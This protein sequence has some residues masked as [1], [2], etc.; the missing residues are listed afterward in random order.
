MCLKKMPGGFLKKRIGL[1]NLKNLIENQLA[2]YLKIN[3]PKE[4]K[5]IMEYSLLGG[6]KRL[7]PLLLML[8]ACSLN[9]KPGEALPFACAVEMIHNYSLIHDDIMDKDIVR[10]GKP[11]VYVKYGEALAILAGDGLLNLSYEIMTHRCEMYP[12]RRNLKA[13]SLIAKAAGVRGMVGGQVSD[14][15]SSTN[16][17]EVYKNKTA[18]L[19]AASLCAGAVLGKISP[20]K[21]PHVYKGGILFGIAFQI[22]NDMEGK[23][24][25]TESGKKT[26]VTLAGEKKARRVIDNLNREAAFFLKAAGINSPGIDLLF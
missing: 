1:M 22:K 13:M 5:E 12:V 6:G 4:I 10:R 11:T 24:K 18:V 16:F 19:I 17:F 26:Y 25:D 23:E 20:Q 2:N 9:T 7:R 21:L 15:S 3:C 8:T 14:I